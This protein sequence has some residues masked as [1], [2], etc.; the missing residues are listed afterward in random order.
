[1]NHMNLCSKVKKT[2][3]KHKISYCTATQG[4]NFSK[5]AKI[6]LI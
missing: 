6:V 5:K 1:M 3:L 4:I 2:M